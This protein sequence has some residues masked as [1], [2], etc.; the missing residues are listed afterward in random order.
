M[1]AVEHKILDN[2]IKND[3]MIVVNESTTTTSAH[4]L[5]MCIYCMSKMWSSAVDKYA[6]DLE[7]GLDESA[8]QWRHPKPADPLDVFLEGFPDSS[9]TVADAQSLFLA[10][11]NRAFRSL[12]DVSTSTTKVELC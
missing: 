4:L 9:Y 10:L 8:M 7:R 3:K 2:K 11:A 5:C 12:D 6:I 1:K